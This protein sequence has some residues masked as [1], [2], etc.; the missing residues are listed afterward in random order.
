MFKGEAYRPCRLRYMFL[1][2]EAFFDGE[3]SIL[4]GIFDF[5]VYFCGGESDC[6]EIVRATKR[7]VAHSEHE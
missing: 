7:L 5:V 4:F 3:N 1:S 2:Q 6:G